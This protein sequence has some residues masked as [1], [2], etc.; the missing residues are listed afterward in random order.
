MICTGV[1]TSVM[2]MKT[3]VNVE[4]NPGRDTTKLMDAVPPV[5]TAASKTKMAMLIV[6]KDQ[7]YQLEKNALYLANA[8]HI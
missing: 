5:Q 7:S 4:I 3:P 1:E 6:N 2:E 8:C